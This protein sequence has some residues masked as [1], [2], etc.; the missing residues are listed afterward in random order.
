MSDLSGCKP[1]GAKVTKKCKRCGWPL[2]EI[3]NF[4]PKCGNK[5]E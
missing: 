4:C 3:Y 5:I 2:L 1:T